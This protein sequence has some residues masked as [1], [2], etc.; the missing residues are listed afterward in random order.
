MDCESYR[1]TTD[2][3]SKIEGTICAIG[4]K[5]VREERQMHDR[6]AWRDSK[7]HCASAHLDHG[8]AQLLDLEARLE[9]EARVLL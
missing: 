7:H 9:F 1:E 6:R 5:H 4:Q 8:L 3:R 2:V